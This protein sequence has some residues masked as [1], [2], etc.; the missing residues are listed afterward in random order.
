[1]VV[2]QTSS[3]C[4]MLLGASGLMNT[5]LQEVNESRLTPFLEAQRMAF[6]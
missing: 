6:V 2:P 3:P 1:M 4:G 5:I